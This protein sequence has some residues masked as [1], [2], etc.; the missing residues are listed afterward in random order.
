[1]GGADAERARMEGA[2]RWAFGAA[3]RARAGRERAAARLARL[4]AGAGQPRGPS[5]DGAPG[6]RGYSGGPTARDAVRLA[7]AERA[8]ADAAIAEAEARRGVQ[9]LLSLLPEGRAR[10]AL[11]LHCV[12]M[13]GWPEVSARLGI[14]RRHCMRLAAEGAATLLETP[15]G[16][17]AAGEAEAA[18]EEWL[19][20]R[21]PGPPGGG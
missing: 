16:R 13:M 5:A 18:R 2:L 14:S 17:R 10:G 11:D 4:R 12:G 15:E 9:A 3:W 7:E 8:V 20:R 21:D 6:G 19:A 1:M